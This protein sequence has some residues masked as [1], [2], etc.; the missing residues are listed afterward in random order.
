MFL[1]SHGGS[2]SSKI[3]VSLG[4]KLYIMFTIVPINNSPCQIK[5]SLLFQSKYL[6]ALFIIS[7]M[8]F[9]YFQIKRS[10][11]GNNRLRLK[12]EKAI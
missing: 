7:P 2:L 4:M 6:I 11:R 1:L 8:V 12:L 3:V 10:Y 9:L 5:E